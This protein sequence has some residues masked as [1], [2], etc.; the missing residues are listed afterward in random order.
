MYPAIVGASCKSQN[1]TKPMHK[2]KTAHFKTYRSNI[3]M[4][5]FVMGQAYN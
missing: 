4:Y 5:A 2:L 3:C 1:F